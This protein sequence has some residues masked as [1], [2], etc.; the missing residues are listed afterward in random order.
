MVTEF[1]EYSSML[2]FPSCA[3]PKMSQLWHRDP[4]DLMILKYFIFLEDI[5][6]GNGP[7]MYVP[8]THHLGKIKREPKSFKEYNASRVKDDEMIKILSREKWI[9]AVG[10]RGTIFFAD[11]K[12]YHK[13]GYLKKGT[14]WIMQGQYISPSAYLKQKIINNK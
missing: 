2:T 13:G 5:D 8:G 11:T 4:E 9:S 12:G 7:F 1:W 14:R 6:I 10:K 3:D